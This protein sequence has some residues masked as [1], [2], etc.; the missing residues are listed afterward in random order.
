MYPFKAGFVPD[1]RQECAV[2]DQVAVRCLVRERD[3]DAGDADA[4]VGLEL[5]ILRREDGLAEPR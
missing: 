5:G 3:Q 1:L 4:R 2:A